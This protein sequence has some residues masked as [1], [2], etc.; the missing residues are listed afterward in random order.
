MAVLGWLLWR[1]AASEADLRIADRER[2]HAVAERILQRAPSTAAVFAALPDAARAEL[3]A[4]GSLRVDD[5]GWLDRQPSPLDIDLVVDDRL[6]RATRAEFVDRDA[7]AARAAYDELLAAPLASAVR[8]RVV[9][10]ACWHA[11]RAADVARAADLRAQL[12]QL[13]AP[14]Q[15]A[16]CG[17][18]A[19]AVA[20]ASALRADQQAGQ[21]VGADALAAFLPP[22]VFAGLSPEP[23]WCAAHQQVVARRATLLA[24]RQA[25]V[26]APVEAHG[27][28]AGDERH[29]LAWQPR[30][31]GGRDLA[32]VTPCEWTRAIEHAASTGALPDLPAPW[33][34]DFAASTTPTTSKFAVPGIAGISRPDPGSVWL[35][36]GLVAALLAV[37]AAAFAFA[38]R[39]QLR[40]ARAEVAAVRTQSEFLT[41]VTHELKTP[42]AAIRLLGEMLAEG[43]ARGRENEYYA[44][45]AGEAGRLSLLIENV[46]DLGRLERGERRYD[47]REVAIG[48]V[49]RETLAM[50]APLVARDGGAVQWCAPQ[51]DATVLADRG[52]LVQALVAVLDNARKYGGASPR[53]D[54]TTRRDGSRLAIDVRDHG[55]GVRGAERERIFERFVRGDAHAHGSTPGVGIGLY[56]ARA[57]THALRGDLVCGDPL[58]GGAGAC[59][60]FL[61]PVETPA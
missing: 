26:H 23:K 47:L 38:V 42:L 14:L 61:L 32:W 40:A 37:L 34:F 54:V 21:S 41:T 6:E 2:A 43:R 39:W 18:P 19:I 28:V 56:L 8:L 13:V 53:I 46:L 1:S 22:D 16:D 7:A 17:R 55:P 20:V 15:P 44:M 27:V 58:D 51:L 60:T 25:W 59:F 12:Q 45:L 5:V 10:A 3:R 48:D 11:I 57:I 49:L 31:D 4:D 36:P 30:A 33:R 35:A 50:F 52:A 24:L 9:A 29:L